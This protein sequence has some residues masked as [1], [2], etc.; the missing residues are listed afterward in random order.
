MLM[1]K[2]FLLI[3][4]CLASVNSYCF[5]TDLASAL[6]I[7]TE[8]NIRNLHAVYDVYIKPNWPDIDYRQFVAGP[9]YGFGAPHIGSR[10][11]QRVRF[12]ILSG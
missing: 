12:L 10:E 7:L 9:N 8:M 4:L 5:F 3:L 1:K 2:H 11:G 6:V